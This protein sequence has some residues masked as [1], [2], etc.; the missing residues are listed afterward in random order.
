MKR[1]GII[2]SLVVVV[3][4]GL[5]LGRGL[6][7]DWF[8]GQI[9]GVAEREGPYGEEGSWIE[10]ADG[11]AS[12]VY[13]EEPARR[14]DTVEADDA[15]VEPD[16]PP[17]PV[18][19][20]PVFGVGKPREVLFRVLSNDDLPLEGVRVIEG[21]GPYE[22]LGATNADGEAVVPVRKKDHMQAPVTFFL[23]AEG[24]APAR[25]MVPPTVEEKEV[26]LE[27]GARIAG[28]VK[29]ETGQTV[30][31]A[32]IRA[33]PN[34]PRYTNPWG[35]RTTTTD[36]GGAFFLDTLP[37][38]G[39]QLQVDAEGY[40]P[41]T[42]WLP[43]EEYGEDVVI[44]VI[45]GR[46]LQVF[47]R[48]TNGR[49]LSGATISAWARMQRGGYSRTIEMTTDSTGLA[50]I[51]GFPTA[52]RETR[53]NVKAPGH[54]PVYRR[55]KGAE[56]SK[57]YLEIDLAAPTA[58]VR[59]RVLSADGEA[60][61]GFIA[62]YFREGTSGKRDRLDFD[63]RG[64]FLWE[65]AP[66]DTPITLEVWWRPPGAIRSSGPFHREKIEPI[67]AGDE[68]VLEL[69][70]PTLVEV[71]A[72]VETQDGEP[73]MG[74]KIGARYL[75]PPAKGQR[76]HHAYGQTGTDGLAELLMP[77]GRY[78]FWA[79]RGRWTAAELETEIAGKTAEV[80]LKIEEGLS[81]AGQVVDGQ[82]SP[83][84]DRKM[85]LRSNPYY[86]ST[87]TDSAGQF[88]F[89]RLPDRNYELLV[90]GPLGEPNG[91][92]LQALVAGEDDL[93]IRIVTAGLAG[94][95]TDR[96][97]GQG[98]A[99]R[100]RYGKVG[101]G[102]R[103]PNSASSDA[104]GYFEVGDL[105]LGRWGFTVSAGGYIDSLERIDV[106]GEMQVEFSLRREARLRIASFPEGATSAKIYVFRGPE[107]TRRTHTFQ[108][109]V[110]Q[111]ANYGGIRP[112]RHSVLV[113]AGGEKLKLALDFSSGRTTAF[114]WEESK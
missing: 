114:H 31:G 110:G 81:I 50:V 55:F 105:S 62:F 87:V 57:K 100:V 84:D 33:S 59:G 70:V 25:A 79:Q 22:T 26:R 2:I 18:A 95:I 49:G 74:V 14:V 42:K 80:L 39:V 52:P 93:T 63:G 46:E 1:T 86:R 37:T 65:E 92:R 53:M 109:G 45:S 5:F 47:V 10:V 4:V 7:L 36:D 40:V 96:Q 113:E 15:D 51:Y 29:D 54:R 3:A 21:E 64:R 104:E 13:P 9:S 98:V 69:R 111:K 30:A 85:Q 48:G 23:E 56:A 73:A 78:R 44:Q 28:L 72:R 107:G 68:K 103:A 75:D 76:N 32:E 71:Y 89:G 27:P 17:P 58:T 102:R 24:W 8:Y 77:P 20:P 82:G 60:L 91:V 108:W 43:A 99:A 67:P 90:E 34:R 19:A 106:D 94:R 88:Y 6:L 35:G 38:G 66:A 101:N 11:G 16:E 61:P 97:T 83:V 41:L 112:G 12:P